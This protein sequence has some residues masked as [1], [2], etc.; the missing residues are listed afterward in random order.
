M[1]AKIRIKAGILKEYLERAHCLVE[2]FKLS[3]TKDGF[4]YKMVD[5]AHVAMVQASLGSSAFDLLEVEYPSA[6]TGLPGEKDQLPPQSI[7]VVID[8]GRLCTTWK[9]TKP[10]DIIEIRVPLEE[11]ITIEGVGRK[12]TGITAS[13]LEIRH[14]DI[15][16]TIRINPDELANFSDPKWPAVT[17]PNK[18]S[19]RTSDLKAILTEVNDTSDHVRF[20]CM[21]SGLIVD[22]SP[23]ADSMLRV[24]KHFKVEMLDGYFH[25]KETRTLIALDYLLNIVGSLGKIHL[26]TIELGTDYPILISFEQT[27]GQDIIGKGSFILAPRID[28][29]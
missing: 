14:N 18:I 24:R 7:D 26:I 15:I 1:F 6:V 8:L 9:N 4:Y 17:L 10:A 12:E 20:R 16:R 2:E 13:V 5:P 21:K 23:C 25:T 11:K 19:M 28:N 22:T 3:I 27:M 29:D